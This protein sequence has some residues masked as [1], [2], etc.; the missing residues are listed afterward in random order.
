[1]SIHIPKTSKVNFC[2]YHSL[3]NVAGQ[4]NLFTVRPTYSSIKRSARFTII[5][6]NQLGS[7]QEK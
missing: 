4:I 5:I 3:E 1:M 6:L 7:K 2:Q